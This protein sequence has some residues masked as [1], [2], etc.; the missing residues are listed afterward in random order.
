MLRPLPI[1]V[2]DLKITRCY[3]FI[4]GTSKYSLI[5]RGVGN[6][7]LAKK[8]CKTTDGLPS[9]NTLSPVYI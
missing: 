3:S 2:N 5:S 8:N 4:T 6:K 9:I 1:T 7:I